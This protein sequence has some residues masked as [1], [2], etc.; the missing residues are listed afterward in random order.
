LDPL[1]RKILRHYSKSHPAPEINRM[2]AVAGINYT[3]KLEQ[4][5]L[6]R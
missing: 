2:T 5:S 6:N 3:E 4:Q 1:R